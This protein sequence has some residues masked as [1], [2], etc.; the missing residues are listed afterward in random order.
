[1]LNNPGPLNLSRGPELTFLEVVDNV[2]L[3]TIIIC[4]IV[5]NN[6]ITNGSFISVE[7]CKIKILYPD[8]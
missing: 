6:Q 5:D 4:I 3:S 1:M 2:N 7:L 8:F